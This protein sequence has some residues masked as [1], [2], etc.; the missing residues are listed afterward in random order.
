MMRFFSDFANIADMMA[1]LSWNEAK[2]RL[3]IR[4]FSLISENVKLPGC[5]HNDLP[6][7]VRQSNPNHESLICGL[8][9]MNNKNGLNSDHAVYLPFT[10]PSV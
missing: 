9:G 6:Q 8:A 2:I 3:L 1:D 7:S 4:E 5:A 10:F